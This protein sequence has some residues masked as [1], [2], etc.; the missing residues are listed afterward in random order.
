MS[1]KWTTVNTRQCAIP[2]TNRWRYQVNFKPVYDNS[3][4]HEK[5]ITLCCC[6][7]HCIRLKHMEY[8]ENYGLYAIY[9]SRVGQDSSFMRQWLHYFVTVVYKSHFTSNESDSII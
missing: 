8:G 3:K 7:M 2:S 1:S 6:T 9:G 4:L 5:D